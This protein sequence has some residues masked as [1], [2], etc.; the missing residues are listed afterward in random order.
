MIY[1]GGEVTETQDRRGCDTRYKTE[2][3]RTREEDTRRKQRDIAVGWKASGRGYITEGRH[4]DRGYT[5]KKNER[6]T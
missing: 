6:G 4:G 2:A 5:M 1:D 3:K